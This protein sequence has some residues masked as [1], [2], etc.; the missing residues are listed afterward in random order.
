MWVIPDFTLIMRVK[1]ER[2]IRVS[3]FFKKVLAI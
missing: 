2:N 1:N 3:N